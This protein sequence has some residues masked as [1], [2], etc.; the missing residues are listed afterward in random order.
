MRKKRDKYAVVAWYQYTEYSHPLSSCAPSFNLLGLTVPGKSV[1]K[2]FNVWILEKEKLKNKGTNK[3]QQPD[4][5]THDTSTNCPSV[6][7][8]L[9]F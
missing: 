4:S 6:Y 3:K 2:I 7:Q 1:T 9:T 8:V 5:G